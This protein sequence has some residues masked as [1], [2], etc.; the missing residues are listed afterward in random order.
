MAANPCGLCFCFERD[1]CVP[2]GG[3]QPIHSKSTSPRRVK[4]DS[5]QVGTCGDTYLCGSCVHVWARPDKGT[6][7]D[8][9]HLLH[10][11]KEPDPAFCKRNINKVHEKRC[12]VRKASFQFLEQCRSIKTLHQA[13]Y[14]HFNYRRYL[15]ICDKLRSCWLM[16]FIGFLVVFWF[17]FPGSVLSE[18]LPDNGQSEIEFITFH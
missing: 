18:L 7:V 9:T 4:R 12:S 6:V 2:P 14:V 3:A 10:K 5:M 17:F 8:S 15:Q 13:A 16:A 11:C 1:V